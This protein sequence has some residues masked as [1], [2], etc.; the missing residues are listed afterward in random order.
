MKLKFF[1]FTVCFGLC[2]NLKAQQNF[3]RGNN[4]YITPLPP[5]TVVTNGLVLNLDAGNTTSY[6]GTGNTWTDLSSSANHGTL[7]NGVTY[8][9]G[10]GG[11]FN[12]NAT[13][14]YVSLTP[15][16][17]PT[18][19]SDRT[20]IAFVKTPTSFNEILLHIIHWGSPVG[21]QAYGLAIL[22]SNGGLTPHPWGSFDVQGTVQPNTNYCLAATYVNSTTKHNTWINGVSQGSGVSRAINTG[23]ADARIGH[24][25]TGA[26]VWG[27]NGQIYQILVYNRALS[28]SEIQ[29]NFNANKAKYGL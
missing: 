8:N 14:Q 18:G 1:L 28:D 15:S 16:K 4:N 19:T 13:N 21:N 24:R 23:T 3:F 25:V 6:P 11:Y 10:N 22:Q 5:A 9:S 17:L 2:L 12:F 27:P 20:V 26:E 7:L 29:Q